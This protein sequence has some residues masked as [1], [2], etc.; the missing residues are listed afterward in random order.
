MSICES[1]G[2]PVVQ[3]ARGRPRR[4]C[5]D[6]CRKRAF[7]ERNAWAPPV[8]PDPVDAA[9]LRAFTVESVLA[10][11]DGDAP[12]DPVTQLVRAV[13]ETE[14][15][16]VEYQR[17]GRETPR[18]LAWRATGMADHL[19]AGLDRLFPREDAG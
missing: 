3:P 18:N 4:Y 8:L 14:T 9:A 5:T 19:R 11:L 6:V 15:L 12:A 13:G 17:L 10:V 7:R 1:C 2:A 16:A